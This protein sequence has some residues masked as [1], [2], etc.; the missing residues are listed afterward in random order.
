MIY[1]YL[2]TNLVNGKKYVGLRTS[3][4]NDYKYFGSGALIKKAIKKYGI[5]NFKKEILCHCDTYEEAHLNEAKYIK[6]YN[7][8]QP[9]GY[10]ID[11]HGGTKRTINQNINIS[12][13][14]K[15]YKQTPEHVKHNSEARTG[16]KLSAQA[17]LNISKGCKGM[18]MPKS[19]I[20]KTRQRMLLNNPTKIGNIS[21]MTGKKHT[22]ETKNKISA[23][24]KNKIFSEEYKEKLR[25]ATINAHKIKVKC[26]YCGK[27]VPRNVINVWHNE[28]C[29]LKNELFNA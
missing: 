29:K 7:T 3:N 20:E 26:I 13:G 1:N 28:K 21:P 17:R 10:N 5:K 16:I 24:T 25:I 6:Q 12:L 19:Q 23:K 14:L 27:E 11:K 9:N 22:E 8:L 4:V 2:T 18:K 15:G